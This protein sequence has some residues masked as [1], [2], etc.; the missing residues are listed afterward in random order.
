MKY[1]NIHLHS[2]YSD[3]IFTPEEL[4]AL[5]VKMGYGAIALAD[6]QTDAGY[7]ELEI[8]AKKHGLACIRGMETYARC[9]KY[10]LHIT[11]YDFDP[12]HPKMAEFL[13][14]NEESAHIVTKGKFDAM[15]VSGGT[16]DLTWQDVLDDAA[17]HAW[18]CNEQIFAS[19]IK[20]CGYTQRDYW[21]WIQKFRAAKSE[22]KPTF[23]DPTAEEMIGIIRDAGGVACLA[24]P[25]G[26]TQLLPALYEIGLMGAE[27]DHPDI[28]AA[29]TAAVLE[30]ARSHDFYVTGG[31]DHTGL[32]GDNME[33]GDDPAHANK[34]PGT[35]TPYDADVRNGMSKEEFDALKQR[36]YG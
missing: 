33:R 12:T 20:R 15:R 32:A 10:G 18:L 6:H 2:T 7:A 11:A 28:F 23:R 1:A 29:D 24:H 5:M 13:R 26:Q 4:C 8:S 19:L 34:A 31:T 30:F 16:E 25:H 36:I 3:G 9:E 35:F 17:P 14:I 21:D 27:Y 22:A